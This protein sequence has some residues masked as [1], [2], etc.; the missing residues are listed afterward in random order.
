MFSLSW[1]AF[2]LSGSCYH[3]TVTFLEGAFYQQAP[4]QPPST[5]T[6]RGL[7]IL[8]QH[9]FHITGPLW[10]ESIGH[11]WIPLL[12]GPFNG[13]PM[14]SLLLVW[15]RSSHC[16]F[17]HILH[18]LSH[19]TYTQLWYFF[20]FSRLYHPTVSV[21]VSVNDMVPTITQAK[22]NTPKREYFG[23]LLINQLT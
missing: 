12:K 15:I 7:I 5:I 17:I 16:L 3:T 8:W 13:S 11:Q 18:S 14:F 10:G 9:S 1:I 2:L 20:T 23:E 22:Q 21:H 4:S 19:N 6:D